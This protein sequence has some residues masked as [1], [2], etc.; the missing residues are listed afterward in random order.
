MSTSNTEAS[1][2][3]KVRSEID[4]ALERQFSLPHW[5]PAQGALLV[6]GVLPPPGCQKIPREAISLID[7]TTLATPTQLSEAQKIL[8]ELRDGWG[9]KEETRKY[10]AQD[11]SI[12]IMDF[13]YDCY[14]LCQ[15]SASLQPGFYNYFYIIYCGWSDGPSSVPCAAREIVRRGAALDELL[16]SQL[17]GNSGMG[18]SKQVSSASDL[19]EILAQKEIDSVI[20]AIKNHATATYKKAL[21]KAIRH[22]G[23]IE[24]H[25]VW[26]ALPLVAGEEGMGLVAGRD[27][28]WNYP[29]NEGLY[30]ITPKI[31]EIAL[32][33]AKDRSTK[34]IEKASE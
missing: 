25:D 21:M 6:S 18:T 22:C 14:V 33:R 24:F 13:L 34:N 11:A 1:K 26:A 20:D 15:E 4:M 16:S 10:L 8:D 2:E 3:F 30:T 31:I 32:W 7:P 27:G 19:D 29:R 5:T 23:S 17:Q 28:T 9:E 12:E